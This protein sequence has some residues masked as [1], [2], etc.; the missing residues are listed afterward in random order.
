MDELRN[1]PNRFPH[2]QDPPRHRIDD[3]DLIN[4]IFPSGYDMDREHF[5]RSMASKI[6]YGN[7]FNLDNGDIIEIDVDSIFPCQ[8][9]INKTRLIELMI[10]LRD[11][12]VPGYP[13][14]IKIEKDV[15]LLDGHHRV[16]AQI[17]MGKKKVTMHLVTFSKDN[18][19]IKSLL[20]SDTYDERFNKQDKTRS[21]I[22][23]QEQ[24]EFNSEIVQ[25]YSIEDIVRN[26][27]KRIAEI[28]KLLNK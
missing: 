27:E 7:L 20:H 19:I 10:Y 3:R 22:R 9:I 8:S 2:G 1:I 23:I 14:G 12:D 21:E 6:G 15:Y 11:N 5:A 26:H 25:S 4:K 28:E 18:E 16:S 13:I 24:N 17:L